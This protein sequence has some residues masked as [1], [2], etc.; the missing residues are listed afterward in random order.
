M[1]LNHKLKYILPVAVI[2]VS[3]L[4]ALVIVRSKPDVK[5]N[6]PRITPK[7]IKTIEVRQ[8][9]V[10]M[11]VRSQGSVR[12]R[13]ESALVSQV[14]G[15]VTSVSP[16]FVAGGFFEEGDILVSQDPRDYA[17]ILTQAKHQV[18][19]AA[20]A[21]EIEK[22]QSEIARE[23]WL[24]LNTGEPPSLASRKPQLLEARAALEAARA[25]EQQAQLNMERTSIRAPFAGRVRTKNVDVGQYVTPGMALANVYAI[26]YAEVR[27]S[28]RDEELAFLDMPFDFRGKNLN[29]KGPRVD[30]QARFAGKQHQW[31]GYL[32]H[33]EA[34]VDSRSRMIHAV[35]RVDNPYGKS[36]DNQRPPLTVGLFVNAA[37]HGST[38]ENLYLL[39]RAAL[40]NRD[41]VLVVD[42]D[43]RLHF[44][45]V[46]SFR[47]ESDIAYISSGLSDG[48]QVCVSVIEAV[49][50]GM[51]VEPILEE[52]KFS[53]IAMQEE[54]K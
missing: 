41:E 48:E 3:I 26:D 29:R 34:E 30:L 39:P 50:D 15:L 18:A 11:V 47:V 4:G 33:I 49:V 53:N 35:V 13:T 21:L 1:N 43:N 54:S 32:T 12:A 38:V 52:Y 37:I 51:P 42:G 44:R 14:A 20:L 36:V 9:Q 16:S 19:K 28:L 22:Q 25:G 45:K 7:L 10:Q 17:F 40:R 27:L 5:P 31:Q 24:R 6:P 2:L 46:E 8:K 23:E